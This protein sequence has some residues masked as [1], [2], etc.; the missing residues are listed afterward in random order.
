VV[1]RSA[2]VATSHV[3]HAPPA[4]SHSLL[5]LVEAEVEVAVAAAVRYRGSQLQLQ[6]Q[7]NFGVAWLFDLPTDIDPTTGRDTNPGTDPDIQPRWYCDNSPDGTAIH[8]PDGTTTQTPIQTPMGLQR[9]LPVSA[10]PSPS[11]YFSIQPALTKFFLRV[12]SKKRIQ[13]T[14]SLLVSQQ[15]ASSVSLRAPLS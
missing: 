5:F 15:P 2:C 13:P 3:I 11:A 12:L 9:G 6:L 10:V 4:A 1:I 14:P 8:R 7:F